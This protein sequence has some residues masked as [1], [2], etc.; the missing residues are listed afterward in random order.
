MQRLD[1]ARLAGI[2]LERAAQF[3]NAGHQRG[4]ADR[5]FRPDRGEQLVLGDHVTGALGEERQQRER[6]GGELDLTPAGGQSG[7]RLQAITAE[8]KCPIRH[9]ILRL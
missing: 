8:R 3:L 6:L 2:V 9:G 1:V 4:I 7:A 5:R